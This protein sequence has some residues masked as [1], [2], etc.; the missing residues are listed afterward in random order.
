MTKRG[1]TRP[2]QCGETGEPR[3]RWRAKK[4]AKSGEQRLR[5]GMGMGQA[6]RVKNEKKKHRMGRKKGCA[7]WQW[8][9]RKGMFCEVLGLQPIQ[10]RRWNKGW[11]Y[12]K[13]ERINH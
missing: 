12:R 7:R 1:L 2:L 9:H 6:Q 11:R 3:G 13:K 5:W 10:T 8:E 4:R